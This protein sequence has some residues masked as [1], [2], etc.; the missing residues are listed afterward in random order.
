LGMIFEKAIGVCQAPGM[1]TM[2]GF[3]MLIVV[4]VVDLEREDVE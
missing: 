4:D 2:W 3:D 1:R